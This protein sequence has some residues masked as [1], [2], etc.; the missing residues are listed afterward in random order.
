MKS[1]KK[2][3]RNRSIR[4]LSILGQK[5]EMTGSGILV[6]EFWQCALKCGDEQ[7]LIAAGYP[8]DD[9]S[10]LFHKDYALISYSS[11]NKAG[12]LPFPIL[13]MSDAMPYPSMRFAD[14]SSSQI[15]SHINAFRSAMEDLILAFRPDVIHIHHL[16]VLVALSSYCG[17]IPCFVTIH[18][19]GLKQLRTAPQFRKYVEEGIKNISHFFSVSKDIMR[20][21][22]SSYNL[23]QDR[24]SF[25]GN[26]YNEEIFRVEGPVAESEDKVV[27]AAGK[28]VDWK[29]FRFLIRACGRLKIPHR[30]VIAGSGPEK[31]RQELID[32]A[33]R[34]N[35]E[36]RVIL[37][38]HIPQPE[39]AKW[40]RRADV[41]VLPSIYEPFGL[42]FLEAM[43]C[44]SPIV[45]SDCGGAK[46]V[47]RETGLTSLGLTTLIPPL[48]EGDHSDENRYVSDFHLALEKHLSQSA[49]H[50]SRVKISDSVKRLEWSSIYQLMRAEYLK[51]I[52]AQAC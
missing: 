30:L 46:D 10:D 6:R 1:T 15:E 24:V 32:E 5:P 36:E 52:S 14:A 2:I 19:T 37:T 8:D 13:G 22:C 40:M 35:M 25:I 51:A 31:N 3:D 26:G 44:G 34:N 16:W 4:I 21:A 33:I 29:G 49:S 7:K 48:K 11:E 45:A 27:L 42:V 50:L 12:Q 41:F 23:S 17:N 39:L 38:G 47:I 20:D 43:A 28:F 18:G 9:Y